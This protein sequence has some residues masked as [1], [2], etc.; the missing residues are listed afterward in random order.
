MKR[1]RVGWAVLAVATTAGSA[2]GS[3]TLPDWVGDPGSVSH[4]Y[5]FTTGAN[6]TAPEIYENPFDAGTASITIGPFGQGWD[7]DERIAR[8]DD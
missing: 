5:T 2:A 6:P 4:E 8:D 1:W 3:I 7:D